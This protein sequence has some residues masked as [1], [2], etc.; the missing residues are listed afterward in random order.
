MAEEKPKI[1]VV[2]GPTASGKSDLA[3]K[4][5][6]KFNGEI[7]SAD[8]RQIYRGMDIGTAKLKLTARGKSLIA[9]G[10]PHYLIGIKIPDQE[11]SAAEY[12]RDA[13]RIIKKILHKRKL[14]ILV[15]GT[16]LYVKAVVENLNIPKVRSNPAL[17]MKLERELQTEGLKHLFNRLVRLDPEAE[18]IVDRK[19]PRRVIRALEV[20]LTTGN[21][22]S[23]QRRSG[24][25]LFRALEIGIKLSPAKLRNNINRR[26]DEMIKA[27]L[28]NEVQR[29]VSRYDER[30]K[31]LDAIGYRE[32]ID[33]LKGAIPPEE[34]AR[35]IKVNTWHYAKRQITWF[36]KDKKIIWIKEPREA[37]GV[38]K[39]FL[40]KK[41]P[42][43]TWSAGTNPVG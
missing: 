43:D 6:R 5:A 14:P 3:V 16:G 19:N 42:A 7:V 28:I 12:K 35:R 21:P 10:I 36:K 9:D 15:G 34:A 24:K 38:I 27:G 33:Y 22:F 25:P 13:I 26:V 31:A 41:K 1:I 23:A 11:Y 30:Y 2:I 18:Y 40:E 29:L 39:K 20:A 8:S 37:T 17:R 4:I 32:I